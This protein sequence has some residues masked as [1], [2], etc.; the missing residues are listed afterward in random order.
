MSDSFVSFDVGGIESEDDAQ[1]LKDELQELDGVQMTT[2]EA[3]GDRVEV[4][5]GE[6]LLSEE[7]IKSKVRDAGFTVE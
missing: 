3:D 1:R 2:V 6:E 5:Y 4:R 7:R